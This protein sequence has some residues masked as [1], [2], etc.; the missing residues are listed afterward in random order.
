MNEVYF[1]GV[2]NNVNSER[3]NNNEFGFGNF[4]SFGKDSELYAFMA[5]DF[6]VKVYRIKV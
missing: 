1:Y 2:F 5:F 3:N 4:L 6:F